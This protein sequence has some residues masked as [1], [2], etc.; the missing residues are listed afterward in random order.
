MKAKDYNENLLKLKFEVAKELNKKYNFVTNFNDN[1]YNDKEGIF[2]NTPI[3]IKDNLVTKDIKTTAASKFLLDYQSPFDASVVKYLKDEGACIVGKTNMDELAMGANG[4]NSVFGP[5]INPF[6]DTRVVGGSSSGSAVA[7][8]L[9]LAPLAIASD[10]GDSI[11]RP[12][13]F[14]NTIGFKPSYGLVSR[15]GLIPYAD[16]LDT[17]GIIANNYFDL[18]NCFRI[19]SKKDSNDLSQ[20][21]IVKKAN[22]EPYK[23]IIFKNCYDEVSSYIKS[24]MDDLIKQLKKKEI[25]VIFKEYDSELL[26]VI[27]TVYYL[28][29]NAEASSNLASLQGVTFARNGYD[30]D[31]QDLIKENRSQNL[32][33]LVKR[34]LVIGTHSLNQDH[35]SSS[36]LKACK[37]RRMLNNMYQK[38]L[39]DN[40]FILAPTTNKVASYSDQVE[41]D[42][43]FSDAVSENHLILANFSGQP[44]IS[45]PFSFK[46]KMPYGLSLTGSLYND[47]NLIN[48]AEFLAKII[49]DDYE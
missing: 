42:L 48:A 22:Q 21:A 28:I 4:K 43:M 24:E 41:D 23:F 6:D 45:I 13:S 15:F 38:D 35:Y 49:G 26:K 14:T 36:Y 44:S 33:S 20:Q 46:N 27:P 47:N 10:T 7:V 16:S 1:Y 31:Y 25:E 37:V 29:A 9:D 32:S 39:D 34:R 2:K 11:R 12:A 17:I 40:T 5:C 19:I 3:Y 30:L 8:A 18:R